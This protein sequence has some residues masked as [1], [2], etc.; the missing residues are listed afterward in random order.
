[1]HASGTEKKT[2]RSA[3]VMVSNVM[4][5][6]QGM[7]YTRVPISSVPAPLAMTTYLQAEKYKV[8]GLVLVFPS[9]KHLKRT[10]TAY[11]GQGR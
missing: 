2:F 7:K 6:M 9:C 3:P 5:L 4:V 11:S 10:Q 8:V 1:M